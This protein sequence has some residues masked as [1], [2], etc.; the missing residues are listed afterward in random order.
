VRPGEAHTTFNFDYLHA[1]WD[2]P[3]LRRVIDTT[4]TALA[5]HGAPA[6]W[7]FASHD[8]T[9]HAT[10][11]GR[12]ET[13]VEL[14][15]TGPTGETPDLALGL[16]RARAS[17]LLTLALPGS[18]YLY[19]GEELGLPEVEDLPED[20][21]QDPTWIRSGRTVRGRD[22]CRVP[23]PWNGEQP[24]FGFSPEGGEPWLPQPAGWSPLT[25]QAQEADPA[26]TLWLYRSALRLRRSTAALLEEPL[27]WVEAGPDVLAFDRGESFRCMVNFSDRPVALPDGARPLLTSAPGEGRLAPDAAAWLAIEP[28]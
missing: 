16:R 26:S 10:R 20:L 14:M 13:G 7:V 8:E 1:P 11:F 5:P 23:L 3:A 19:Q 27:R 9:R 6:T 4:L 25:V 17:A 22:G 18:A 28:R 21:L 12:A 24:P 15:G 2:G